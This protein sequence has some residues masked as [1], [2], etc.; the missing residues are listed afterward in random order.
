MRAPAAPAL[1]EYLAAE[2]AYYNTQTRHL[3]P[4][5]DALFDEAVARTADAADSVGWTLRDFRY[6]YRTPAGAE[7]RQLLRALRT[8]AVDGEQV[9]LDENALAAGTGFVD[10]GT[11]EVSPDDRLLA[12]SADTSGAEIYRLRF[13]DLQTGKLVRTHELP[14]GVDKATHQWGYLAYQ[15]GRLY[16]TATIR[17]EV[18]RELIEAIERKGQQVWIPVTVAT[19]VP[20]A[21]LLAVPFIEA[22]RL[23]STT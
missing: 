1:R 10:I 5:T 8:A 9:L 20:G 13:T 16:G 15:N 6:W 2:R 7:G 19:L 23:F 4:L 11:T 12:W 3:A 17:S 14:P 22:L 18:H 21:V